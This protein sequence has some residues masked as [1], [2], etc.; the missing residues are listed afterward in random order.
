MIKNYIFDLY[1]T[2]IDIQTDEFDDLLWM[3]LTSFMASQGALYDFDELRTAYETAVKKQIEK[4]AAE[5]PA[6]IREH[7]EPDI[8]SVFESLY[9]DKNAIADKA[10]A[11]ETALL[12][13]R[14]STQRIRLYPEAREV[15]I[16]LRARG[17]RIFLLS[18]AQ[19]AFTIPEIRRLRIFSF[20]DGI[21]LSSDVGIKKPDKKIFEHI[22]S[23]YGLYPDECLMIGND[24]EDDMRGACAADI[25]GLYIHSKQ[26][27]CRS[28]RLPNNCKEIKK[29]SDIL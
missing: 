14:L 24:M 18:N 20:F 23:K 21:V 25:A 17:K 10:T 1:G 15:L 22:L 7:I 4:D 8:L 27:P 5:H 11:S 2:L 16:E 6:I 12:F 13:R 3:R 29:L 9:T 26:S 28:D 19:S